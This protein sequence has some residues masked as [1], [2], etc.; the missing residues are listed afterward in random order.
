MIFYLHL[1]NDSQR[2]IP[3]EAIPALA[4]TAGTDGGTMITGVPERVRNQ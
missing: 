1:K 2:A 4:R 3:C